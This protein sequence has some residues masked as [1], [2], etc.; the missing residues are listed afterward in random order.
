MSDILPIGTK[1]A[2]TES[3]YDVTIQPNITALQ[4]KSS[5]IDGNAMVT[6]EVIKVIKNDAM[7]IVDNNVH[8]SVKNSESKC[9]YAN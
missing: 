4:L 1:K 7:A 2:A 6:D 3:K 8:F 5:P 9:I